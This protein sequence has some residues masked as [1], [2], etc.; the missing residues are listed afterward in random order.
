MARMHRLLFAFGLLLF[1]CLSPVVHAE[2][3]FIAQNTSGANSGASCADAHNLSWFNNKAN[4]GNTTGKIGPGDTVNLCGIFNA[5]AGSSYYLAFRG[6]GAPL[7]PITLFFEP[8][9]VIQAPYWSGPVIDLMGNSNI[10]V[11]GGN[12]GLIQATADGTLLANQQDKGEGVDTSGSNRK[13][14]SNI[15]IEGLTIANIYV[16]FCSPTS[17]HPPV[18]GCP[19]EVGGN[20]VGI[21]AS[22]G[23]NILITGN[24]VHDTKWA[25]GYTSQWGAANYNVTISNNNL[26]DSDHGIFVADG[27]DNAFVS[28]VQIYGNTIHDGGNWDDNLDYNHHDGIHFWTVHNGSQAYNVTVYDNY[29]YGNW[30]LGLNSFIYLSGFSKPNTTVFNNILVDQGTLNHYGCGY[31][32]SSINQLHVLNNIVIGYATALNFYGSNETIENNLIVGAYRA[33]S[34]STGPNWDTVDYNDYYSVG[35]LGWDS[36]STL[37]SWQSWCASNRPGTGCDAHSSLADPQLGSGY[38]PTA[39]STGLIKGGINLATLGVSALDFDKSGADRPSAGA[40]DIGAYQ[41]GSNPLQWTTT[42]TTST[43]TTTVS[44]TT[45]SV[46]ATTTTSLRSTTTSSTTTSTQLL[47]TSTWST[48]TTLAVGPR[49]PVNYSITLNLHKGWNMASVPISQDISSCPPGTPYGSN[50]QICPVAAHGSPLIVSNTCNV[51]SIWQYAGGYSRANLTDLLSDTGYWFNVLGDCSITFTGQAVTKS[52]SYYEQLVT[53]W[54]LVYAPYSDTGAT[55]FSS[56]SGACTITSGPLYYDSISLKYE[57][58][59]ILVPGRAYWVKAY[60]NC[61]LQQNASKPATPVTPGNAVSQAAQNILT[62]FVTAF[63]NALK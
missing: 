54:N 24:T 28:G 19:D 50:N 15:T 3:F 46:S 23:N 56:L 39:Q 45:T 4:W 53:G 21:S 42:T 38:V 11:D 17:T 52:D 57:G 32:C 13:G 62:G 58:S 37:A 27:E 40:W 48:T 44:S 61:V 43:T 6:G 9:A 41:F 31:I 20:T 16:H 5:P 55:Q 49:F 12:N 30:G 63:S 26:F 33:I 7:N 14:G 35:K 29:I 1:L 60:S 36:R 47:T 51:A 22:N 59:A 10:I 34:F 18:T 25:I 8:G 2:S